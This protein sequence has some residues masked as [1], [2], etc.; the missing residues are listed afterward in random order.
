DLALRIAQ[1]D[2]GRIR[3]GEIEKRPAR[4][5]RIERAADPIRLDGSRQSPGKHRRYPITRVWL[6]DPTM[7]T[8]LTL[9]FCL[10]LA[11]CGNHASNGNTDGGNNT[12]DGSN[13]NP[14]TDGG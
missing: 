4:A 14:T 11:A 12:T 2:P 1:P 6:Y 7:R 9:L 13:N 5:R 3:L 8:S 10:S